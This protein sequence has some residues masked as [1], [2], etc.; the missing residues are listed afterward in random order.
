MA[1]RLLAPAGAAAVVLI[2]AC[3]PASTFTPREGVCQARP[4]G[5]DFEV[6]ASRTERDYQVVGTVDLDAFSVR[7]LPNGEA[8]FREA[9]GP[10]VC[11]AGGDAVIPGI[12]GDG[13]YVLASVVKWV[14][15]SATAPACTRRERSSGRRRPHP[16]AEPERANGTTS[17]ASV[18]PVAACS[19]SSCGSER[20]A[21]T[22]GT[23]ARASS[24]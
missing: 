8:A 5:C 23:C 3:G 6:I 12:T 1:R 17:D 14:D 21:P 19:P 4:S 15:G 20:Q 7:H 24:C 9:V 16:D 13:R 2:G 18:V 11:R 10:A 22:R